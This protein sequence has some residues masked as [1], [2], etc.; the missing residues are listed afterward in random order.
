MYG[1]IFGVL[2][3]SG[4]E[5]G[6][7]VDGT[8]FNSDDQ[9]SRTERSKNEGNGDDG[10][11]QMAQTFASMMALMYRR[12]SGVLLV[13]GVEVGPSRWLISGRRHGCFVL[14]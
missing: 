12:L 3:M 7:S 2:L 10:E 9:R 6:T 11:G 8:E 14:L 13:S 5:E 4:G 1:M